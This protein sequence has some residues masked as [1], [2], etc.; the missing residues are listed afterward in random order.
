M[1]QSYR[2]EPWAKLKTFPTP[3]IRVSPLATKKSSVAMV[4]PLKNCPMMN[5]RSI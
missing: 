3:K 2:N 1:P 4:R 5:E